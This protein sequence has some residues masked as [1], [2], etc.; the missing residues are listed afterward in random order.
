MNPTYRALDYVFR[1]EADEPLAGVVAAALVGLE[2]AESASGVATI[3]VA[4]ESDDTWVL[5]DDAPEPLSVGVLGHGLD[6][7]TALARLLEHVNQ[8]AAAS[9]ESGVALHAAT[10]TT[11]DGRGFA[12]AGHSGSG[13]STLALAAA[14]AGW[15]LVAE[16][17]SAVDP[18]TLAV[19]P[20]PRPVGLRRGGASALGLAYPG[21]VDGS[22]AQVWPRPADLD[23]LAERGD[24]AAIVLVNREAGAAMSTEPVRQSRA[25]AEMAEHCIVPEDHRLVGQFRDLE[26]LVRAVPVV[27]VT[28]DCVGDGVDQLDQLAAGAGA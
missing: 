18:G 24:L 17:L 19:R 27:R 22:Y 26:R 10:V 13:K 16:E 15:G 2:T 5:S 6:L 1:V 12:L 28:Y 4:R 9:L 14:L 25:L 8:R 7:G 23:S 11:A 20:Y 3:V 21:D